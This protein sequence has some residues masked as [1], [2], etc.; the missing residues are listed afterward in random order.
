[1]KLIQIIGGQILSVIA[2]N[3]LYNR[4]Y[5]LINIGGLAA[6][7]CCAIF[8]LL[9]I[10]DEITF[11][12]HHLNKVRIYRLESDF[13]VSGR[14]QQVAKTS[15]P[16]GPVF[17][18]TFPEIEAF[19]RF[20]QVEA[21]AVRAGRREFYEREL[22]YADSSVF[23]V[24]THKFIYGTPNNALV[25]PG[26]I[27]L[28]KSMSI[29]YFGS[30]DPVGR[31]LELANGLKCR[32]TAV[33]E[34]IPCNSHMQFDGL[35]SIT[36]YARLIGEETF[37]D[38]ETR[39]DWAIRIFTFILLK[40]NSSMEGIHEKFP[41]LYEER[42]VERGKNF[43]ASYGLL[44]SPLTDIHLY[45]GLE[46]DLPTG[47]IRIIYLF[48]AIGIFILLIAAIN[49]MNLATARS[50]GKARE[51]GIRKVAGA[52]RSNLVHLF[53]SESVILSIISLAVALTLADLMMPW[54]NNVSGKSMEL[55]KGIDDPVLLIF[56]G[57]AII[58]GIISGLYPAFY[59]SSFRPVNVLN[60]RIFISTHKGLARKVL[61]F[62]Q[63]F[64][65]ISLIIATI[66]VFQQLRHIKTA[67]LGFSKE[68]LMVIS[69]TDSNAIQSYPV[70][71]E[72]FLQIT[73]VEKVSSAYFVTGLTSAMDILY[74]QDTGQQTKE[75]MSVNFTTHDFIDLMGIEIIQGRDFDPGNES[76]ADKYIIINEAAADKLGWRQDPLGKEIAESAN[77]E[78][79]YKVI[80][81][82][83]DFHYMPLHQ[84]IGPMVY[85]LKEDAQSEIH[86]RL[87]GKNMAK[88]IKMIEHNWKL[89][90]PDLPF[91]YIFLDQEL[92]SEYLHEDKLLK[93]MGMF[94]LFSIFIAL[95]GLFG[96][97]SFLTEQYTR[98]IG[99]RK[100]FGANPLTIVYNLTR[101]YLILIILACVVAMP[102][103][104]YLMSLWLEN[105]AYRTNIFIS[106]FL[107]TGLA[108]IVV[109]EVTVIFQSM[110]AASRNPSETLRYE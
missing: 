108:V 106:W 22:F 80:G 109:A 89:L 23:N 58:V 5:T 94:T 8:I 65:S 75:L 63:F 43:N 98:E 56:I 103:C 74:V 9:F 30:I 81:V 37:H 16:F 79:P 69:T 72:K 64:I 49:Y 99:I 36:S 14:S 78:K 101:Q 97:S 110:K 52:T 4:F 24:F 2:R 83:K 48:A 93:L 73:G 33:I 51:V 27:V 67:D 3:F 10:K 90:H 18:Q 85:F 13:S 66:V 107:F 70:L 7:L 71:R 82:M 17:K 29:R 87:N 6:G 45:S 21:V 76:D 61:M 54:F 1:M 41:E 32:V 50:A 55:L 42:M 105:F 44:S 59:L 88:T 15:W 102:L 60:G 12:Q 47:D 34:D 31:R 20:R 11:D 39:Q 91:T 46:W 84:Q 35:I 100:V 40:E 104:W 68:N 57:I 38:L 95:L 77:P 96:L 25:E 26:A 19:V 86:V 92:E 53:I 28:T 62:F